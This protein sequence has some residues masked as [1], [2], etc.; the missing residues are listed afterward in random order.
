MSE[1]KKTFIR[2]A[3]LAE[4]RLLINPDG[5]VWPC[6]YLANKAY[7][8]EQLE[9]IGKSKVTW[10]FGDEQDKT[11][12]KYFENKDDLNLKNKPLDE[13][14]N[15]EWYQDTLPESWKHEETR[16]K[17]C[18]DFCEYNLEDENTRSE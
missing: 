12:F 10:W 9:K 6:C 18:R 17:E 5:Q 1:K 8:A 14:L 7:N 11:M 16:L 2:C 13:I 15:H 4:N 3:W